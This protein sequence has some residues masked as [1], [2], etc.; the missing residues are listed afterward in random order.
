M[1]LQERYYRELDRAAVTE[2]YGHSFA[3]IKAWIDDN[4]TD[5]HRR[6]KAIAELRATMIKARKSP[7]SYPPDYVLG[8]FVAGAFKRSIPA[9]SIN[10]QEARREKAGA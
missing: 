4:L 10:Q 5:P 2:K 6:K 3:G 8:Q 7:E 1:T 9:L